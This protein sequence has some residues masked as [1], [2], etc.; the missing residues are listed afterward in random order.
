MDLNGRLIPIFNQQKLNHQNGAVI[1]EG[2]DVDLL[3]CLYN[4]ALG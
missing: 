4:I 1:E 3:K 2:L